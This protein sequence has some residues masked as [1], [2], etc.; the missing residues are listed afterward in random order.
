MYKIGDFSKL[1]K[2]TVKALR[3]YE[4]EGLIKPVYIDEWTGYRYYESYQLIDISKIT[5]L[6]Q[7][8]LSINEIKQIIT[9]KADLKS[10]LIVK[11][12]EIK[13][14]IQ[15]YSYYLSKINYLLEEK[16]MKEE[17]FEKKVS[18]CLIFYK[19]GIL[20]DYSEASRFILQA[21]VECSNLNPG[22]KCMEP[23]YSFM[24][25]LDKEYKENN[26]KVRYCQ[27]VEKTNTS[28]K[29]NESIKFVD[30][31]EETC[32]CIYHKGPYDDLRHSYSKLLK[33]IEENN[34]KIK[35]NIREC[36]IDGIWNK[37]DVSQWLTEI[38]VPIKKN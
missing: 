16:E 4:K 8:G 17:I 35:D 18:S 34:Y 25:Y 20:T 33:Y 2:V 37:E 21:G 1:S 7:I 29:E 6:K 22:I 19:E 9:K 30:L 38:Q 31:P 36:Y 10:I 13:N 23:D 3:F 14:H 12:E 26:I 5:S 11:K 15:E 24:S 28:Y 27:A 32:I